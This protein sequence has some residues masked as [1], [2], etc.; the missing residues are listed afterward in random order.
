MV[1]FTNNMA[2]YERVC[3]AFGAAGIEFTEVEVNGYQ[4]TFTLTKSGVSLTAIIDCAS[5][6][7]GE[8]TANAIA[9]LE[10]LVEW[11]KKEQEKKEKRR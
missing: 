1:E 2:N 10:R 9:S 8:H 5:A 3:L 7:V 11:D 6:N 4:V